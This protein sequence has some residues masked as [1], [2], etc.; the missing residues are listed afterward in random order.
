M[1]ISKVGKRVL[2]FVWPKCPSGFDHRV[3]FD[4][5]TNCYGHRYCFHDRCIKANFAEIRYMDKAIR[6]RRGRG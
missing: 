1:E 5:V 3:K 2:D 6:S 4:V